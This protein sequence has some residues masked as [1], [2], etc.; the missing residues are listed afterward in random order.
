MSDHYRVVVQWDDG[1]EIDVTEPVRVAYDCVRSSLDWGSGF[2]DTEEVDNIIRL[3]AACQFPD[4]EQVILDVWADREAAER[5]AI[6]RQQTLRPTAYRPYMNAFQ[7]RESA[8]AADLD[9]FKAKV[10]GDWLN[11]AEAGA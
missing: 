9:A 4:F 5:D 11:D 10:M 7:L 2:L 3:S 8:T 1:R 6:W